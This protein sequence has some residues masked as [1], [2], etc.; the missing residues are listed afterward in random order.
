MRLL[1]FDPHGELTL[2]EDA[3]TTTGPYAILSHT[4]GEDDDEVTFDDME[5]KTGIN[6]PGYAKLQC[7]AKQVGNNG[8]QYFWI[9]TCCI[10]K[11]SSA[12]LSEAINS[13]YAWYKDAAICYVYLD[14]V[15]K[16]NRKRPFSKARWFTRGWT[17]QELLAPSKII[18][19]DRAWRRLGNKNTLAGRISAITRIPIHVLTSRNFAD[20]CVAQKLSWAA[21]RVTTRTEDKAYSLLGLFGVNMALIYGEGQR[22]FF[23]L[24]EEIIKSE[25]DHT[26]FAWS[27][28]DIKVSGLLAPSPD[29]FYGC[30]SVRMRELL[31]GREPFTLTNRGLTIKLR[32]IPW[33]A[34]TYLAYVDC[35]N[36]VGNQKPA[37]LGIFLRRLSQDDQYARI[38]IQQDGLWYETPSNLQVQDR[39]T[40]E[41]QL[42]V[43]QKQHV[44]RERACLNSP[45]YGF[46]ISRE[47]A[48]RSTWIYTRNPT[49]DPF[50]ALLRAGQSGHVL[51]LD[52]A[53]L[54]CNLTQVALGFDFDFNPICLLRESDAGEEQ[55]DFVQDPP[56]QWSYL[57]TDV[58][59]RE[60]II[61]GAKVY[62]RNAQRGIWNLAGHRLRGL[63][64]CLYRELADTHGSFLTLKRNTS[65]P[66]SYWEFHIDNLNVAFGAPLGWPEM[67]GMQGSSESKCCRLPLEVCEHT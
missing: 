50:S 43:R 58:A 6:K 16:S 40:E 61:E 3:A 12:E 59:N 7:C 13:M 66:Q 17:L 25:D 9:D 67:L 49:N 46:R 33:V 62:R 42:Y 10:N 41:R 65:I 31:H 47:C 26:I 54:N 11:Q 5:K 38:N 63:D 22:A 21:R 56:D 29:Y 19:Y 1:Q 2:T 18:F 45:M 8:L 30:Q 15:E 55:P 44:G 48:P 24:Q 35:T 64:V 51:V 37:A 28:K 36:R 52:F 4:W 23:R 20:C 39:P 34:D 27:M 32:I 53:A 60:E 14:D 57:Y